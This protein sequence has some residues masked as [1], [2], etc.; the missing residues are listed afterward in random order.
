MFKKER[1]KKSIDNDKIVGVKN[2]FFTGFWTL[3]CRITCFC[4]WKP[5]PGIRKPVPGIQNPDSGVQNPDS[6]IQNPDSGIQ[7]C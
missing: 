6:G 2:Q 3:V 7:I 5:V 1:V 4:T